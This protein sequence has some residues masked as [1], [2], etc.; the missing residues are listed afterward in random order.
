MRITTQLA[1]AALAVGLLVSSSAQAALVVVD[2]KT[3]SSTGGSGKSSGLVLT[4]GQMFHSTVAATD[5]WSAGSL[6]RWSNA[7][8][9]IA[10]LFATGTDDSGQAAGIQIGAVFPM[11]FQNGLNAPFNSLVGEIGGVFK[12]LGTNFNGPSWGNGAL[13]LYFWDQN[14]GDNT[15]F[16]TADIGLNGV[17]GGVPEPATWAMMIAGF[18]L[19]GATLRRRKSAFISA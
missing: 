3:N 19:V 8:G 6:P 14:S 17:G 7:D 10:N 11:W 2:A 9:L 13:S 4:T 1:T 18:G 15:Q 16:I 5:L 12:V